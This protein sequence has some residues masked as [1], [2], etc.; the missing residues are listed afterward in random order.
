MVQSNR[1]SQSSR[2]KIVL[3][4]RKQIGNNSA[5]DFS[6]LEVDQRGSKGRKKGWKNSE[7]DGT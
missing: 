3:T 1:T 7:A 2:G 6:S 5:E 4:F